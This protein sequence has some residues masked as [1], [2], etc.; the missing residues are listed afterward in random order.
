MRTLTM[1]TDTYSRTASGKG[2]RARPDESETVTLPWDRRDVGAGERY[3]EE[4]HRNVTAPDTLAWFRRLGGSEYVER[5]YTSA[6]FIV[7][8]VISSNPDRTMRKVRRFRV[9]DD[10][11]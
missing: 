2:W 3:G 1:I 8:R 11:R 7:T 6:G 9:S 5:S 4:L 10:A